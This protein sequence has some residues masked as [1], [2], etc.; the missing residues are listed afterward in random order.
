M[1]STLNDSNARRK[2]VWHPVWDTTRHSWVGAVVR[3]TVGVAH[4]SA[5]I[6]HLLLVGQLTGTLSSQIRLGYTVS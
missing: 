5:A 1:R 2:S 6:H 4:G 3:Y